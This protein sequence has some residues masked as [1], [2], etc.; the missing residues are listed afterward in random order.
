MNSSLQWRHIVLERGAGESPWVR[1]VAAVANLTREF[2]IG[3]NEDGHSRQ[4]FRICGSEGGIG[5]NQFLQ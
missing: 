2:H 3:F 4:Q 5:F 1:F